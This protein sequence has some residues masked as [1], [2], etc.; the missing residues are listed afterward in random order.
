MYQTRPPLSGVATMALGFVLLGMAA[1]LLPTMDVRT[2]TGETKTL[3]LIGAGVEDCA[4]RGV[5]TPFGHLGCNPEVYAKNTLRA[6]ARM[7]SSGKF[8]SARLD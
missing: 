7:T 8:L 4:R 6:P 1:F 2:F 5:D 3:A